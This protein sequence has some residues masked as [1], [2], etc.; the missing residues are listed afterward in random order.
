MANADDV[1]DLVFTW[2]DRAQIDYSDLYVRLYISYNAWFRQVTR[3]DFDRE[4]I[5]RLMKRFIIWDDYIQGKVLG[6]LMPIVSQIAQLTNAEPLISS[7]WDGCVHSETDWK[8]LIQYWYQVRCDLFHGSM[9]LRDKMQQQRIRL[10]YESLSLFMGEITNRMAKAFTPAD[11]R[12]LKEVQTLLQGNT[13]NHQQLEGIKGVLYQKYIN[14][15]D[16]WKVDMVR[17]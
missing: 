2:Y 8:N 12:R 4:A 15:P 13:N 9:G 14:S 11:C 17:V 3:T 10:A 5:A 16:L 7:R 6:R 1:S